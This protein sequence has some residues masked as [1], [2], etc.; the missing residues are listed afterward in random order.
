M[1]ACPEL[2]APPAGHRP[3][4]VQPATPIQGRLCPGQRVQTAARSASMAST[5]LIVE[6]IVLLVVMTPSSRL[7]LTDAL[8]KFSEPTYTFAP[9]VPAS[10]TIA[11]APSPWPCSC[12]YVWFVRYGMSSISA[13]LATGPELRRYQ[14]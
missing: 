2:L 7:R 3:F 14:E 13:I 9:G 12:C 11:L 1:R 8:V 6:T 10:A 4:A 5:D